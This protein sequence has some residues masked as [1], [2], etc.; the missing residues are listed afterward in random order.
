MCTSIC[1][2]FE[3][4]SI[5]GHLRSLFRRAGSELKNLTVLIIICIAYQVEARLKWMSLPPDCELLEGRDDI[6]LIFASLYTCM[7]CN[8]HIMVT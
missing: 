8:F 1:F 2:I 5:Q 4:L 3:N 7:P 6:L